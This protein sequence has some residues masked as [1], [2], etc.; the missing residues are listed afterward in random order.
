MTILTEGNLQIT[1]PP[2]VSARRFDDVNHG[3]SHCMKAVDFIIEL[4][5]Q[6]IFIEF[7]DPEHPHSKSADRSKFIDE[8]CAGNIDEDLKYKYRDSFLYEWA[9]KRIETDK[10]IY[11]YV[12]VALESLTEA[13]LLSR[14]DD[15]KR[16]L[17]LRGPSSEIWKRKIVAD[18]AVFNITT[19]N[20]TFNS[21][22]V[23]RVTQ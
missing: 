4:N 14:T 18:C 9:A 5:D 2:E 15:L 23:S 21:Y 1:F 17:P 22:P 16:K 19:W 11:Y 3:L 20:K 7:K 6:Y 10:P 13:E 8:F 12:L